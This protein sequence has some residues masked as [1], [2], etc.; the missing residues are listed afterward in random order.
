[1]TYRLKSYNSFITEKNA[2]HIDAT[3]K[4]VDKAKELEDTHDS[5]A[6]AA[7]I[8]AKMNQKRVKFEK[9]K[10]ALQNMK[11]TAGDKQT[12]KAAGKS[13]KG[14]KAKWKKDKTKFKSAIQRA[15]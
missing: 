12:K 13:L 8:E 14:L 4:K 5:K 15:R 3:K 1:M 11:Q 2:P 6:K 9:R 7:Q 10:D